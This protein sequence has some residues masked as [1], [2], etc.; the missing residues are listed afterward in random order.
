VGRQHNLR[1][2]GV[3]IGQYK[4]ETVVG[5]RGGF[6]GYDGLIEP[7]TSTSGLNHGISSYTSAPFSP[8]WTITSNPG[9]AAT[10]SGGSTSLLGTG[11]TANAGTGI[12]GSGGGG[13]GSSISG[14]ALI[15]T[16]GSSP[17][18]GGGGG[19]G[20]ASAR[21]SA[22][23][24]QT[25][26]ITGGGGANATGANTAAGGGGGGAISYAGSTTAHYDS[27]TLTM[28]SGKGGDSTAGWLSVTYIG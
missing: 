9:T 23:S 28:T 24:N 1:L 14:T 8:D 26:V 18:R 27:A 7:S 13:G 19:G 5:V 20:G 6:G 3:T 10:G 4:P 16:N 22:A 11:G 12:A 15:A 21:R 17:G 25:V 2:L